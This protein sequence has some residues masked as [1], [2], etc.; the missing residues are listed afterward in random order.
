MYQLDASDFS[1][2]T[3]TSSN[4]GFYQAALR[5]KYDKTGTAA[6]YFP[7][8]PVT[9]PGWMSV[10]PNGATPE[11]RWPVLDLNAAPPPCSVL[12]IGDSRIQLS[13]QARDRRRR[14][15]ERTTRHG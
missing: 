8:S 2:S 14:C 15:A 1:Q 3:D 6:I 12:K 13:P 9:K 11:Y 10:G 7:V 4:P 5:G